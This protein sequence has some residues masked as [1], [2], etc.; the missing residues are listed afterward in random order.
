M[1]TVRLVLSGWHYSFRMPPKRGRKAN[2]PA[3]YR[4]D[5]TTR[6]TTKRRRTTHVETAP[7]D[8]EA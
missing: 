8:D 1:L 6:S 2:R 7:L 4:D 3:R 5:V